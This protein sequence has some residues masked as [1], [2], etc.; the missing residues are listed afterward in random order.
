MPDPDDQSRSLLCVSTQHRD[1][2]LQMDIE[3]ITQKL[4]GASASKVVKDPSDPQAS[5]LCVPF[6][7][8]NSFKAF[9]DH[10]SQDFKAFDDHISQDCGISDNESEAEASSPSTSS[11][12]NPD[13]PEFVPLSNRNSAE[14]GNS[15][16]DQDLGRRVKV[17]LLYGRQEQD[18]YISFSRRRVTA[19]HLYAAARA[20][21]DMDEFVLVHKGMVVTKGFV[22]FSL[23]DFVS[24][25]PVRAPAASDVQCYIWVKWYSTAT[26]QFDNATTCSEVLSLALDWFG[27]PG[28]FLDQHGLIFQGKLL[29]RDVCLQDV[30]VT[31]GSTLRLTCSAGVGGAPFACGRCGLMTRDRWAF[32][33][34]KDI[35]MDCRIQ[36]HGD[37]NIA[38]KKRRVQDPGASSASATPVSKPTWI[39]SVPRCVVC[40]VSLLDGRC[41]D[42]HEQVL[43][44]SCS[45]TQ[46]WTPVS[47][48]RTVTF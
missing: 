36:L 15:D 40:M 44:P 4:Y 24:V 11:G 22:K 19:Q 45:P 21:L 27:I 31:V 20:K 10:I 48:A 34:T 33:N 9:V 37:D 26:I 8:P 13:A 38:S 46:P 35:C 17:R 39:P 3:A 25:E 29:H 16:S 32:M 18:V 2:R 5:L 12:L 43:E 47:E 1:S 23:I 6:L 42:G 28:E 14:Q 41:L 7:L 30:G